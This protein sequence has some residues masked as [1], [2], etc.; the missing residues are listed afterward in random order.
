MLLDMIIRSCAWTTNANR[1]RQESDQV[2]VQGRRKKGHSANGT[3]TE[4]Q[5]E[6]NGIA[7]LTRCIS[8]WS[9]VMRSICDKSCSIALLGKDD[10]PFFTGQRSDT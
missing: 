7:V 10:L 3:F 2:E 5:I 1:R 4:V 8:S 6:V 9:W